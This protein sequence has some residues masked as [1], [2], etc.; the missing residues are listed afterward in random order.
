VKFRQVLT[1]WHGSRE[2]TDM[3][4]AILYAPPLRWINKLS[5]HKLSQAVLPLACM[6]KTCNL[7]SLVSCNKWILFTGMQNMC[8]L[9]RNDNLSLFVGQPVW[10]SNLSSFLVVEMPEPYLHHQNLCTKY[11]QSSSPSSKIVLFK[12][13]TQYICMTQVP[14]L[15]LTSGQKAA[16]H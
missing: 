13:H 14:H 9:M 3:L 1:L 11:W 12:L 10:M 5:K 6:Y 2:I 15:N 4:I 8:Y 7:S 16:L